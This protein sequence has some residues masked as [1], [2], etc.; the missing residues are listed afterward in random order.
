[1]LILFPKRKGVKIATTIIFA[2]IERKESAAYIA[3]MIDYATEFKA[4][5]KAERT[6]LLQYLNRGV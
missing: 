2:A 6:A 1:M 3:G 4:I 5:T